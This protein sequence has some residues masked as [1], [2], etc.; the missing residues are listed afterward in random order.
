MRNLRSSLVVSALLALGCG[1][2]SPSIPSGVYVLRRIGDAALP[3]PLDPRS[4]FPILILADTLRIPALIRPAP[5]TITMV[6]R[7]RVFEYQSGQVVSDSSEQPAVLEYPAR[8]VRRA[9]GGARGGAEGTPAAGKGGPRPG[10][11]GRGAVPP[12]APPV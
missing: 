12:S 8:Q 7:T 10:R 3:A 1:T 9:V 11:V 4:A 2:V 5:G 6:T